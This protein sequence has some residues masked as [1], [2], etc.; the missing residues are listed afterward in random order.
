MK[1]F[2]LIKQEETL[3]R[4]HQGWQQQQHLFSQ[5]QQHP[6]Q[7][8]QEIQQQP[9]PEDLSARENS[10]HCQS[11][12]ATAQQFM[13]PTMPGGPAHAQ[14]Q[15]PAHQRPPPSAAAPDAPQSSH[16]ASTSSQ[17]IE[18]AQV[19]LSG[20]KHHILSPDYVWPVL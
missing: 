3:S 1:L 17:M 16:A 13:P 14:S 11:I 10:S 12:S 2:A 6:L 7:Q 8:L 18:M 19:C 9:H 4:L 5:Q 15:L 20:A